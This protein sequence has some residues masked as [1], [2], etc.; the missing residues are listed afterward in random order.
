MFKNALAFGRSIYRTLAYAGVRPNLTTDERKTVLL[1][2]QLFITAAA[3]NFGAFVYYFFHGL[4][5]SSFVNMVTGCIFMLGIYLNY[6]NRLASARILNVANINIYLVVINIVEGRGA[7]E[8]LLYFPA[9][10]SITFMVRIYKN[11]RELAFTY[12]LTAVAAFCCIQF[13]PERTHLQWI[14]D[15]SMRDIFSSRLILSIILTIYISYLILR[16]NR[17]N[18]SLILEEKRFSDSIYNSSLDGV[19]I[20]DATT[21][22]VHDCNEQTIKMFDLE[23][24]HEIIGTELSKWFDGKNV[25]LLVTDN[26]TNEQSWQG[27]MTVH[28]KKN[29]V[30]FGYCSVVFFTYK[31]TKYLKISILD[32]TNLKSAEFELMK[33]KEKAESAAKMKTRFLSNM[34][35]ELRTPLNG[36]IGTTNLL[37]NEDTLSTQRPHLDI[38]KYSSEH[39][40]ALINDILDHTK[41][42]AG[43]ME[44]ALLPFNMKEFVEKVI[45][46]FSHQVEAKGLAFKTYI[47]PSLDVELVSDET[48]IQQVLDNLISN[49]IK[50]THTGSVSLT[51]RKT[52]GSSSKF[53]VEFIVED[54]GIGIP[55]D[56][57]HEVF[58][59]FTQANVETTRK[60]GG[61]GLGLTITRE[62]LQVF[63][64]ELTL[65]SGENEGSQ[66]KFKLELPVSGKRK[67][68]IPDTKPG[69]S[70]PELKGVRILVAE[71]NA[72][73]MTIVKR[74][75]NKWGIEISEAV[76]GKIAV[77][78]FTKGSFDLLLFDL[79]MPEMDGAEALRE[80]RKMDPTVPVM[81]FTAAVYENMQSD[82][83][84]KGFTDYIHKPFRPDDLHQKI[85]M[86]T[87][88][89]SA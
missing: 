42:E 24:K 14:N 9:F 68:Y 84:E 72:V 69:K 4:F 77:D 2:N 53:T 32:I 19:F 17:E 5:L 81:A 10:I 66:F 78:M 86:Y 12:I 28:T 89:E 34:S 33:A 49:A 29:R 48:R 50:F 3:I 54:T 73:N 70:L 55:Y 25:Q 85:A 75:L 23:H 22:L 7:G 31:D 59:S 67:V 36:I 35:H 87:L 60:Y 37:I 56:K 18:E 71:D 62:L 8:Y 79:E 45:R 26:P 6:H 76:N 44:L 46:H 16:I 82:L 1:M 39:M 57:R 61:T 21:L 40:L 38:L 11:Y 58:E 52:I 74:F 13:V 15:Q 41:M 30:F 88:A 80:I 51:V 47:D 83:K 64:S 27:E 20:I 65:R 43:K 63:H